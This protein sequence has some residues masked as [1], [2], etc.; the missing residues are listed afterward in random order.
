MATKNR[1][2]TKFGQLEFSN[3]PAVKRLQTTAR[4]EYKEFIAILFSIRNKRPA[5][6]KAQRN[7]LL[8]YIELA[9]EALLQMNQ[10]STS[11]LVKWC[12]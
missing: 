2:I 4:E 12:S 11:A 6:L 8:D 1:K 3:K 7:N 5:G 9:H 10:K